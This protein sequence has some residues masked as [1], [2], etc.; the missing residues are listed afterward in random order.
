M[1]RY[2][3]HHGHKKESG[4]CRPTLFSLHRKWLLCFLGN[5]FQI[6]RDY[7]EV[8]NNVR[9]VSR[10]RALNPSLKS[11]DMWLAENKSRIPLD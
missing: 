6:Y 2:N 10:S 1:V 4:E 11:F 7:D 3:F 5:M 9:D 8:C